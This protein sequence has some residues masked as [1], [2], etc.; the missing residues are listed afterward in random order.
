MRPSATYSSSSCHGSLVSTEVTFNTAW[1]FDFFAVAFENIYFLLLSPIFIS[2]WCCV[3]IRPEARLPIKFPVF[4]LK[5]K[6]TSVLECFWIVK[7]FSAMCDVSSWVLQ[8]FQHFQYFLSF[9]CFLYYLALSEFWVFSILGC[10]YCFQYLGISWRFPVFAVR[11]RVSSLCTVCGV[12][13]GFDGRPAFSSNFPNGF[14]CHFFII[15]FF[16]IPISMA[17]K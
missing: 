16:I 10:Q 11:F 6:S 17:R 13:R 15:R 4:S 9:R 1:C 3:W 7:N 5:E 12:V 14:H 8:P 2:L